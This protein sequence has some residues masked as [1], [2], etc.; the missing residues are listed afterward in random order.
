MRP[1]LGALALFMAAAPAAAQEYRVFTLSDGRVFVSELLATEVAGLRIMLPPGETEVPFT[2]LVDMVPSDAASYTGQDPFMVVLNAP[3]EH[4]ERIASVYR[5]MPGV[6]V[7]GSPGTP[8][9]LS[10]E[11][12]EFANSCEG[13]I[14]CLQAATQGIDWLYLVAATVDESTGEVTLTSRL[15]TGPTGYEASY[16]SFDWEALQ[17][18]S[19]AALGLTP[20]NKLK[21]LSGPLFPAPPEGTETIGPKET[22]PP[23]DRGPVDATKLAFVPIPG[24]AALK[25]G[26]YATFGLTCAA[27]VPATALWIAATGKN[28]QT[29]AEHIAMGVGGFYAIT[30]VANHALSK[31]ISPAGDV[32]LSVLPTEEGG[33]GVSIHVRR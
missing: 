25:Q 28:S 29:P 6:V 10:P 16:G 31:R 9:V 8:T 2:L 21:P 23:K 4:Y 22:K 14:D 7:H 20:K 3:E 27:V 17:Q 33:A 15:N 24:L 5:S 32:A 13:E 26:D 30:V 12:V 19:Y 11:Q 1:L 18:G